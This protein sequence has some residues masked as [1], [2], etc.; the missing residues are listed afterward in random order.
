MSDLMCFAEGLL[1][2]QQVVSEFGI[3]KELEQKLFAVLK[4]TYGS[5]YLKRDAAVVLEEVLARNRPPLTEDEFS[6]RKEDMNVK[7]VEQ[8]LRLDGPFER[9]A[10]G[11]ERLIGLLVPQ[12]GIA[13]HP[14]NVMFT[15]AE[16]AKQMKLNVQ[17][18]REWCREGKLG[19][20]T[21]GKWLISSDEIK[22]YLRGQLLIKGNASS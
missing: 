10:E 7:N 2:K 12:V 21:G 20:K 18:V 13:E 3:P 15:P 8:S 22:Q 6:F 14:V 1:S 17:T 19:V 16:A 11:I 5:L 4:P 9:I